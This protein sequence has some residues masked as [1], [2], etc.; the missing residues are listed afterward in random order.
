MIVAGARANNHGHTHCTAA[1][2]KPLSLIPPIPTPTPPPTPHQ[3]HP[4]PAGGGLGRGQHG[5]QRGVAEAHLAGVDAGDGERL[6]HVSRGEGTKAH[7]VHVASG[8]RRAHGDS[9]L[10]DVVMR[11]VVAP[12]LV[13][14]IH[15]AQLGVAKPGV[16]ALWQ[17]AQVRARGSGDPPARGSA[18]R[19][20][21]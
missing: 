11:L 3:T 19:R 15:P 13:G 2:P 9:T 17:L 7:L 8:M 12:Q 21:D 4:N 6:Q 18:G 1:A 10:P 20:R 14:Q 5:A 16:P